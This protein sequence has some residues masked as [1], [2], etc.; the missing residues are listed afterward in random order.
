MNGLR[1]HLVEGP[2]FLPKEGPAEV[3]AV[4]AQLAD[5]ARSCFL[6][7]DGGRPVG[8]MTVRSGD[9]GGAWLVQGPG[10]AGID[11]AWTSPGIRRRGVGTALLNAVIEWT[12]QCGR[13]RLAVD[14]EAH[15]APARAFWLRHFEPVAW[16]VARYIRHPGMGGTP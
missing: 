8:Y 6:A 16:S 4:A 12:R 14:F 10:T 13:V 5:R 2:V 15:N 7:Y 11:G 9:T 1:R 3:G